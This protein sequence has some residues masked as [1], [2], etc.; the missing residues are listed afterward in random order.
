MLIDRH[1]IRKLQIDPLF[2]YGVYSFFVG[3]ANIYLITSLE[4]G[5]VPIGYA[6]VIPE[7]IIDSIGIFFVGNAFIYMGY[8]LFSKNSFYSV[9]LY[10]EKR[11]S[12]EI[13]FWVMLALSARTLFLT[14][15]IFGSLTTIL[16]VFSSVGIVFFARLW[17]RFDDKTYRNYALVLFVFQTVYALMNSYLRM[18]LLMPTLAIALGYFLG[19]GS[20]KMMFSYRIIPVLILLFLFNAFFSFFGEN[21]EDFGEV[22]GIERI[23]KIVTTS[24]TEKVYEEQEKKESIIYRASV[25]PQMTNVVGLVKNRGHLNGDASAPLLIALIP[26][27]LW[28]DKPLIGLGAWFATEIGMGLQT[29]SWYT[30]SI[31]MTIQGHLFLDF[32]WIGVILGCMLIGGFLVSLWNSTEFYKSSYNITG[33]TLGGYLM[34]MAIQGIGADLQIIITYISYYFIFL[35]MKKVI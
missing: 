23:K 25:L 9:A 12:H 3:I 6:Y 13:L 11:K 8:E 29:D 22:A 19:K 1:L 30:N 15:G 21:R 18:S 7:N 24:Q 28:P 34:L 33:I 14:E 20:M 31:N 26:R 35:F 2:C 32:G 4:T 5:D 10:I 27:F 17:A 16:T